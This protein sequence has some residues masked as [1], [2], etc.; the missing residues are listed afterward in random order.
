MKKKLKNESPAIVSR[1][2]RTPE[3]NRQIIM[4]TENGMYVLIDSFRI[5]DWERT[6]DKHRVSSW[7]Y[8]DDLG[9]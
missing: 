2:E 6:A 8:C 4:K 5:R 3:S 9:L 1:E 7:A